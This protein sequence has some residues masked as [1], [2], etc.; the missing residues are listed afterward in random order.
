MTYLWLAVL[1]SSESVVLRKLYYH[2]DNY[3]FIHWIAAALPITC[4]SPQPPSNGSVDFGNQSPPYVQGTT[5]T[6]QCDDGLFPNDT[7]IATC[8]DMSG[9]GEW[10]P[11]PADLTCRKKPGMYPV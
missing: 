3:L 1:Y 4:E 9:T 8:T 11:N 5:V 10:E 2:N 6:F 7:I